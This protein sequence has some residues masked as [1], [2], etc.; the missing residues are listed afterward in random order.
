MPIS[1]FYGPPDLAARA[2]RPAA[3]ARHHRPQHRQRDH[4][5]L[6]APG[7]R[8]RRL[9]G[10]EI[11]PAAP[12]R[13]GAQLGTGVDVQAYRRVRDPFL[14][15]QYRAPEHAP[16]RRTGAREARRPGGDALSEPGDNGIN[17]AAPE[18]WDSWL[19]RSPT[20]RTAARA[21]QAVVEQA[22]RAGRRLQHGLRPDHARQ[23]Q[24][25]TQST[26]AQTGAG[27]RGRPASP[28][29][30]RR[31]TSDQAPRSRAAAP[32]TTCSTAATSCSTS[33][34][35]RPGVGQRRRATA[36]TPSVRQTPRD[37]LVD[38]HRRRQPAGRH[39]QR[40]AA[41]SARC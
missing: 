35:A 7:G 38:A 1:S 6:L 15:L 18:F 28:P 33:S 26:R 34:R 2:A 8:A 12:Q 16:R 17:A 4:A 37:P 24:R 20:P 3:G 9:A 13:R 27:R 39:D 10:A 36:M 11:R 32:R 5:G 14:D 29:R 21:K 25:S 30:S 22:Q 31:S 41:S 40:P 23:A 19:R